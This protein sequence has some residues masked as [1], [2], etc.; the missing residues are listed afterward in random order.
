V[1]GGVRSV[2]NLVPNEEGR[3]EL[4]DRRDQIKPLQCY[5]D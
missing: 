3:S 1:P 4:P 2:A 5:F